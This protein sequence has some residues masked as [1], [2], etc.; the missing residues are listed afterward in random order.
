MMCMRI[1]DWAPLLLQLLS[2]GLIVASMLWP[3]PTLGLVLVAAACAFLIGTQRR[4]V[5]LGAAAFLLGA[6]GSVVVG[7]ATHQPWQ[8]GLSALVFS[9]GSL[10]VPWLCGLAVQLIRRTRLQAKEHAAEI[11][12]SRRAGERLALAEN[13][14]DELG[15]A[16]SLVAL[17]LARLEVDPTMPPDTRASVSTA[18]SQLSEAVGR[19]GESVSILREGEAVP[20]PRP[21]EFMALIRE[22]RAA[23]ASITLNGV[24]ELSA[25]SVEGR[26]LLSRVLQEALTNAARHAP[27]VPVEVSIAAAGPG[28]TMTVQNDVIP[29]FEHGEPLSS[30]TGL[31]SLSDHVSNAGG[32]MDSGIS[33]NEFAVEVFLPD[34]VDTHVGKLDD[35][36]G[37]PVRRTIFAILAGTAS[38][39]LVVLGGLQVFSQSMQKEAM[40]DA[41][42]FA[43]VHVGDR[44]ESLHDFL[45]HRELSPRPASAPGIDCHDYAVTAS[46]FDDAAGDAYRICISTVT[47]KVV[48][49]DVIRG[50]QR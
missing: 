35:E 50:D 15:H 31:E 41:E 43:R 22:A 10:G 38:V 44:A 11:Y 30:G 6:A 32:W 8:D 23:G 1:R 28:V 3:R 2:T 48:S 12:R 49:T 33:G 24:D 47:G 19:L 34:S 18:R 26:S 45:P 42:D 37:R 17:T 16:L 20:Q 7:A 40:M 46:L 21:A 14:H 39:A 29:G 9:T 27:G 5:P 13:L 4:A 25:V 36:P